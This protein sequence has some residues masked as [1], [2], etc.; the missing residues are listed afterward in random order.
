MG[1]IIL[2]R[3]TPPLSTGGQMSAK[4]LALAVT[5]LAPSAHEG[6]ADGLLQ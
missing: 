5:G 4:K 1:I 2:Y 6:G 3:A